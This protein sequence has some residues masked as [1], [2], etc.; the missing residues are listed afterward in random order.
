M[1]AKVEQ[2]ESAE[3]RLFYSARLRFFNQSDIGMLKFQIKNLFMLS[4][5]I[6]SYVCTRE[7]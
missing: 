5:P 4:V 6:W 2:P 3:K 1:R 7:V